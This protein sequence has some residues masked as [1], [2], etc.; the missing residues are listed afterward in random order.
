MEETIIALDYEASRLEFFKEQKRMHERKLHW[1][2]GQK[3]YKQYDMQLIY[4]K[5]S[6]HGA[7]INYC[8]DAI[9]TLEQE[10]KR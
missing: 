8:E 1:W 9:K 6:F 4:D 10:D 5:C 3:P 2:K 7:A